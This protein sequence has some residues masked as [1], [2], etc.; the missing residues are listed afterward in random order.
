M[1]SSENFALV[2]NRG[3]LYMHI[4]SNTSK[5]TF[6][7]SVSKNTQARK[8]KLVLQETVGTSLFLNIC[9]QTFIILFGFFLC[10]RVIAWLT[11]N[12]SFSHRLQQ[13]SRGVT[14]VSFTPGASG[15]WPHSSRLCQL[16]GIEVSR[17]TTANFVAQS[18][19]RRYV[20]SST[21]QYTTVCKNDWTVGKWAS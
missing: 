18:S 13:R 7:I 4:W 11:G 17:W 9:I 20:K 10:T 19:T 15:L 21:K 8:F 6:K 5:V 3:P 12:L 2:L 16:F 14:A 1:G